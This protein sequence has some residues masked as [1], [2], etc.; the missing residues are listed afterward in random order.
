MSADPVPVVRVRS[1]EV[2][3]EVTEAVEGGYDA[4]AVG[5][6]VYTQ[7]KDWDDLKEMV[8]DAVLCHFD[9]AEAP[10]VIRLHLVR[11]ETL[12][13]VD[14]LVTSPAPR[15]PSGLAATTATASRGTAAGP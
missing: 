13:A 9:A 7:G 12:Q 6:S 8:R 5:H 15:S 1:P 11:D 10:R 3:F 14:R 2:I 4:R